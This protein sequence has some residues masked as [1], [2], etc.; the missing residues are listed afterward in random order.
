MG[1]IPVS[2]NGALRSYYNRIWADPLKRVYSPGALLVTAA[3]SP[4]P[5]TPAAVYN[6]PSGS[7][8][9]DPRASGSGYWNVSAGNGASSL[10][11]LLGTPNAGAS[12]YNVGGN[13]YVSG[14]RNGPGGILIVLAVA[15]VALWLL[16]RK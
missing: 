6:A 3:Q 9:G 10:Q 7:Q 15:A 1:N 4:S 12:T 14:S 8:V 2:R 16:F 13:S 11:Q 5:S